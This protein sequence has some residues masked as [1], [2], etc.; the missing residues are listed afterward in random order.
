MIN[1]SKEEL[2]E[3]IQKVNFKNT[4]GEE[5][6]EEMFRLGVESAVEELTEFNSTTSFKQQYI[7]QTGRLPTCI[8]LNYYLYTNE[9]VEWLESKLNK[10]K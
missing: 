9:Y 1:K 6:P 7:N 2:I 4:N 5:T 8:V 10:Q 3:W